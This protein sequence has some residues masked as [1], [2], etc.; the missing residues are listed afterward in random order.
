MSKL[1]AITQSRNAFLIGSLLW[2]P[3]GVV[4]TS[5]L[6]FSDMM[7]SPYWWASLL[8]AT[9]SLIFV[10]PCG[11]PLPLACR[12]LWRHGYPRAAWAAMVALGLVTVAATLI[13]GLLGPLG[14]AICAAVF[15]APVW[16]AAAIVGRPRE[17]NAG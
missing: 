8:L 10:A 11:L 1:N 12:R 17:P 7:A 3:V 2:L 15:S 6:R 5:F 16:I 4:L 14:I 9:G 13:A